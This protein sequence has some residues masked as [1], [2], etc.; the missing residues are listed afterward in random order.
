MLAIPPV[1]LLLLL[2]WQVLLG[3][4]WGR[5]PV[6]NG[7]VIGWTIF[8]WLVY[9]RLIT[10]RMVTEVGARELRIALRGVWRSRR[11]PLDAIQAVET[12][13]HDIARHY[14]GYGI[15]TA[16]DGRA[17]VA[18]G[19]RGVRLTLKGGEK[20]MVGSERPEELAAALRPS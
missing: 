8:L 15:R 12:V 10:V 19:S 4:K 16:T 2:I 1:A 9:L 3:H 6:S 18:G 14:G 11:I 20:L 17:Y 13:S 5:E 7:D